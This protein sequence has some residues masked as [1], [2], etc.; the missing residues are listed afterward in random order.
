MLLP[1]LFCLL[2]AEAQ[3]NSYKERYEQFKKKRTQE[4][5]DYKAKANAEFAAFLKRRWKDYRTQKPEA[6]P[7]PIV[8]PKPEV[9]EDR[10]AEPL[11]EVKPDLG[12]IRNIADNKPKG[13]PSSQTQLSVLFYG[14]RLEIPWQKE[15]AELRTTNDEESFSAFWSQL[16]SCTD[17]TVDFM[18]DYAEQHHLNGWGYYKLVKN[19]SEAIYT[20]RHNNERIALQAFLLS[21]LRF[22]AQVAATDNQLVLL[23]PFH[24]KV[25]GVTYLVINQ[26]R[27]YI[28]GYGY[29]PASGF[30]TYENNFAYANQELSLRM[31][32]TMMIGMDMRIEL[33]R[34]SKILG[35]EIVLPLDV[36]SIALLLDY[37]LVD[38]NIY[39]TQGVCENLAHYVLAKLRNKI[40]GMSQKQAVGFLLHLV[41]HGFE[42]AT[43]DQMFHRQKQLFIEESFYYGKNNCKDRVG[44]FSWLVHQLVGLDMISIRFEG[45]AESQNIGHITSAVCFTEEVLGD[46]F[47][48]KGKTYVM[49]DPTYIGA[50]IGRTM[51]CYRNRRGEIEKL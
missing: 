16:S 3:N 21:Q 19:V 48:Y 40:K 39:Y 51:P 43:D 26:K 2:T 20:S 23:L 11:P 10:P 9:V 47:E 12:R 42:Y 45:N 46:R 13:Q 7:L 44:V 6:Q 29:N 15:I 49:C 4:Y 37:P 50:Q 31:N 18:K 17:Q 14:N 28:Y 8:L 30:R 35:E 41:Q 24:E 32:G 25:Y 1:L 38:A 34:W 5:A 36:S 27:Y 22:H 33:P